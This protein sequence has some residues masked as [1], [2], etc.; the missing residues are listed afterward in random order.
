MTLKLKKRTKKVLIA[1]TVFFFLYTV[2][3]F[4]I[5]PIIIKS[6]LP[7]KL[8]ETLNREVSIETV[9]LNPYALSLT[10]RD[11]EI[12]KLAGD[13]SFVSFDEFY[14]NLQSISIIRKGP[15]V[16]EVRLAGP[17][18]GVERNKDDTYNF[19]DLIKPPTNE[20]AA[21]E[22]PPAEEV[23]SRPLKFSINNISITKG[24]IDLDDKLKDVKHTARDL[25]VSL[26]FVSNLPKEVEIFIEPYFS[27]TFN[28]T[29]FNSKGTT[30]PFADTR[31]TLFGI[32]LS[33]IDLPY[34][35][36]YSPVELGFNLASATADL[37]LNLSYIQYTDKSPSLSLDGNVTVSEILVNEK[38]GKRLIELPFFKVDISPSELL[39]LDLNIKNVLIDSPVINAEIDRKGELNLLALVPDTAKTTETPPSRKETDSAFT[40]DIGHVEI[41]NG[42][43]NFKDFTT[44]TPFMK[45]LMPIDIKVSSLSTSPYRDAGLVFTFGKKA[46]ESVKVD[47]RVSINPVAAD[48]SLDVSRIDLSLLQPYVDE[49]LRLLVKSGYGGVKGRVRLS[50]AGESG[51]SSTFNGGVS[52]TRFL[53][54]DNA[55]FDD[56]LKIKT[57][58]VKKL[59]LLY[60]TD[61]TLIE[62][63]E[64]LLSDFYTRLI[65]GKDGSFN[66]N[67]ITAAS[68]D[69][70]TADAVAEA[71]AADGKVT[72]KKAL[73]R[74]EIRIA[75]VTLKNGSVN[76]SDKLVN[77]GYSTELLD[78]NGIVTS[79]SSEADKR[80][81][82]ALTAKLDKYAPLE[83]SGK[84]NPLSEDIFVDI[85]VDFRN[86]ELSTLSPYS[87]K[88]I[89]RNISKGKLFM[90]LK[91]YIEDRELKSENNLLIDQI[92]L[93]ERVE[94]KDA[95]S[96]PVGL[97]ISLLKNRAG[98]ID[99]KLPVSG[100]LDDP[101]FSIGPIVVKMVVNLLV[102]AAT[103]PFALL[104]ALVG[105]GEELSYVEFEAGSQAILEAR[106]KKLDNL[107]T[108]LYDRPALKLEIEGYSD[109]PADTESIR[110]YR[111]ERKVKEEKFKKAV[112]KAPGITVDEVTFEEKEYEKYL[113]RAYKKMKFVKP[114]SRIGL[115]KKLEAEEMK[116]LM[117][118]NITVT[119]EEL[120]AIA[121]A[122]SRA[123]KD[124]I[125]SSGRVEEER[126]F[127]VYPDS[128]TPKE[129]EN[130]SA[131]RVEFTLK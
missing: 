104:G 126:V 16:K 124:Y 27:A 94:S 128:L 40:L 5:A 58:S 91:Y 96:L 45:T 36:A 73:E 44:A 130:I 127:I 49:R 100:S 92:T 107:V 116:S 85:K 50:A 42:K 25:N 81:D 117:L 28:G 63:K 79:L 105:G 57:L 48:L 7:K 23:E 1:V 18:L 131:S 102:K 59:E 71:E 87:A 72:E 109:I 70:R 76:F 118:A 66:V 6:V 4:L 97:A 67:E 103:S 114:K 24:S 38:S 110:H 65:I 17:H 113:W 53:A 56:F 31:E 84:V 54:V 8:K 123:V 20:K 34:Y 21:P 61:K 106:S 125:V 32:K 30:K 74:P 39:L 35:F 3:G 15:V 88:Y 55:N 77:A 2:F 68:G 11:F 69:D 112:R 19:S 26:P 12:K 75:K 86:F 120:R 10:V 51:F 43:V 108:A 90:E 60:S 82:L 98:E 62:I 95:T 101:K 33:G 89:A 14:I 83:I 46:K 99:L 129:K 29:E 78:I 122:R 22:G 115:T 121:N 13:E 41:K 80:A 64:V 9:R 93:G 37:E 47:G 119:G 111:F 52:L